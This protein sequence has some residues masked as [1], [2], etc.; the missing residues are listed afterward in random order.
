MYP[1]PTTSM[2]HDAEL[3]TKADLNLL[4]TEIAQEFAELRKELTGM[5]DEILRHFD[6]MVETNRHDLLGAKHDEIEVLKDR[7]K[8]HERRIVRLEGFTGVTAA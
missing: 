2:K 7:S 6:V 8:S 3:A 5:K 1:F 4:K